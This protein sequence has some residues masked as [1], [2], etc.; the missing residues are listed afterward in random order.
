VILEVLRVSARQ[1][2]VQVGLSSNISWT[3]CYGFFN[4]ASKMT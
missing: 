4:I 2:T 3:L 1:F